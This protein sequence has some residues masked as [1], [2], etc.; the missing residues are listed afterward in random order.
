AG[1][2]S[3]SDLSKLD[4]SLG[5]QY[6]KQGLVRANDKLEVSGTASVSRG[7]GPDAELQYAGALSAKYSGKDVLTRGDSLDVTSHASVRG[8]DLEGKPPE[9]GVRA[10]A[11]YHL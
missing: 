6:T 8:G 1:A 5:L 7:A 11:E 4:A 2:D 3:R 9:F 10:S